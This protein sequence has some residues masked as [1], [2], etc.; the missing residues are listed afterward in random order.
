MTQQAGTQEA[1]SQAHGDEH[2][3]GRSLLGPIL[4]W[5]VVFA[6]IGTSVYYVPGILYGNVGK[7]AGFFVL[8]TMSAFVLLTLKY[9]EVTHRFPQGGGVVTVAA[10]AINKW[11][12]ALGGMFILVDYFLTAAL[13][14]LSGIIYFSVVVPAI[15]PLAL[16]ATIGML[17]LLGIL[18]WVGISESAKVSLVGAII[19]FVSD[20]AVL[21]TVF[22][23]IS[24]AEFLSL[25]PAMF[26]HQKITPAY[27]LIGFAGSFLAFSG[28]ESIS[29]LSPVMKIPRKKVA[30][31]A[32]LLVVL[33]IGITSPLLT[34]LSTLLQPHEANDPVLSNQLISLL[35]GHWGNVI[36]QTE[37]AI[38]ASA[39][40]VFASNTAIIGSY[41]V[42]MALSRMEFFPAFVLRRNRLRGTPH[43]SIALAT[44]IPI[45]ILIAAHGN[46]DLLGNMYAFG[47][48]GAFTLT[49]LGLDLVRYRERKAAR[50]KTY[51]LPAEHQENGHGSLPPG[52]VLATT[53][54]VN[55]ERILANGV[56]P[57]NVSLPVKSEVAAT[58]R[59][60]EVL[61]LWSTINLYLGI[62]TTALVMLAWSTNLINKHL[63]TEFG[64]TVVTIG[65]AVAYLNYRYN[66]QKGRVP[67]MI[68]GVEGRLPGSVLAVLTA[69]NGHNDAVI[70]TAVNHANG[71]PIVFL[72]LSENKAK[73]GRPPSM[74]E[75]VDPYLD[76][77][78]AKEYFGKAENLA[79]KA[80]ISRRYVYRQQEPD[81]VARVWQ[82]VHPHDTVVA[83]ENAPQFEDI[84]PDRIR[85][86]L[87]AKGKVAHM[88]KQW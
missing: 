57:D 28:L 54:M 38:S 50:S 34:M 4:C 35:G 73:T 43:Y 33:T 7:L 83:A 31:M 65:M 20:L 24:F 13:S 61:S 66:K 21:F 70:R 51:T 78:K 6:D 85:Y 19:A 25:F 2:S 75:V 46:L 14:C 5:A 3:L 17:V 41:H 52:S 40:L 87:T 74:F 44:G 86:E 69:G 15:G 49:C 26:V 16:E 18:N 67:V 68:T 42:F 84:N 45:A 88:L 58:S 37:M 27:M 63:A 62:L 60:S 72:Y 10:Q 23:H 47:L 56:T 39:L 8:L 81:V 12:G 55:N 71:H 9:A 11:V 32:L 59:R 80:K 53:S 29:Q 77:V 82:A 22:T 79:Q 1:S 36:L 76:D 48:L 64:G 30:G